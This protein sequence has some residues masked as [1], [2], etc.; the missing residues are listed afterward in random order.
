MKHV[1]K[2]F[3]ENSSENCN[4]HPLLL[5]FPAARTFSARFEKSKYIP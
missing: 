3:Y 1:R 5:S 2:L 4:T